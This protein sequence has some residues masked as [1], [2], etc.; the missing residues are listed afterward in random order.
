LKT[1]VT[2]W[3]NDTFCYGSY[4]Y[5]AKGS[6]GEDYDTLATPVAGRLFFAGEATN[7]KHPGTVDGNF[8]LLSVLGLLV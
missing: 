5:V 8:F 7:R 4:S 3:Q 6:S 2:R 1:L